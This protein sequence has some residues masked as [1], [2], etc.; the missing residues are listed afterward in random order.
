MKNS[1]YI[2]YVN[3]S[4]DHRF[5]EINPRFPVFTIAF[6]IFKIEEYLNFSTKFLEFKFNN[7]GHNMT[8]F[9][10]RDIYQDR[11]EFKKLRGKRVK[12]KFLNELDLLI[13]EQDFKII[14]SVSNKN[15]LKR[16]NFDL[17]S[18][19]DITL[20]G[21]L[22]SLQQYLSSLGKINDSTHIIF[23]SRNKKDYIDINK[24]FFD[25][26]KK[27]NY[28]KV[29]KSLTSNIVDKNVVSSGIQLANYLAG[30]IGLS[31]INPNLDRRIIK[32]I[33]SKYTCNKN[34]KFLGVGLKTIP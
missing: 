19:Y 1:G 4:G 15:I 16:N 14:A 6:C 25:Y 5:N 27:S 26:F 23:E 21:C 2:V 28:N 30:S 31:V 10:Y 32:I 13:E 34:N 22:D 7:F 33:E 11:G 9:K 17:S 18:V 20:D 8:V 24:L 3:E 12:K 29:K